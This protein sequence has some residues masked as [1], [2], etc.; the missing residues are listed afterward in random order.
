M[1]CF[2]PRHS[3]DFHALKL[4]CVEKEQCRRSSM[5][6]SYSLRHVHTTQL[7]LNIVLLLC[8]MGL[9]GGWR[10]TVATAATAGLL[11]QCVDTGVHPAWHGFSI[12]QAATAA[13]WPSKGVVLAVTCTGVAVHAS[14]V[15]FR[16]YGMS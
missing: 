9:H 2:V 8:T 7:A 4:P 10:V 12:L 3:V 1:V 5:T 11:Y 16:H 14:I 15:S 6:A 13:A